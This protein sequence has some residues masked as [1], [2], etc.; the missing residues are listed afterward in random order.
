MIRIAAVYPRVHGKRFDMEY[1]TKVHLPVVCLKFVP[2]GLTKV[3]VDQPLESP[4]GQSSPFFAIGYL[5]FPSLS[6]F[7][8]AY[9]AVGAE[10][11][12]DWIKYTDVKPMIQVGALEYVKEI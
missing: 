10:V 6:H 11:T 8:R 12:A 3:E 4:G 9:A 7:Q 2:Y 1:Y 5:Y